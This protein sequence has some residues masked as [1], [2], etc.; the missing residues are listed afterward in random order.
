MS[1]GWYRFQEPEKLVAQNRWPY[2][3]YKIS[4]ALYLPF[5]YLR[6]EM[7]AINWCQYR[8]IMPL[9]LLARYSTPN[10]SLQYSIFSLPYKDIST[11]GRNLRSHFF[12]A[13]QVTLLA[14]HILKSSIHTII[15][16]YT[17]LQQER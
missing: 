14:C 2:S 5:S 12:Q 11:R 13:R 8:T 7:S 17:T 6:F 4:F 16:L 15:F 1:S 3:W 9:S 10:R